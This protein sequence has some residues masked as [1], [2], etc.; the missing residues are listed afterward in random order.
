MGKTAAVTFNPL[1]DSTVK[2]NDVP[3]LLDTS[4][5]PGSRKNIL[6]IKVPYVI[7]P[8][9]DY[10]ADKE[11]KRDVEDSEVNQKIKILMCRWTLVVIIIVNYRFI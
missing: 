4:I 1:T 10:T 11:E 6:L 8:V 3:S 5:K 2:G 9:S 7:H